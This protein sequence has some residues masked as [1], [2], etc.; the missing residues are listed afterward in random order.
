MVERQSI[1]LD[2]KEMLEVGVYFGKNHKPALNVALKAQA[3]KILIKLQ[4]IYN[5]PDLRQSDKRMGEFIQ[6]LQEE[7]DG[8]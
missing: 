3:K 1:L 5:I 6:S 7:V 8:D 2:E 4:A